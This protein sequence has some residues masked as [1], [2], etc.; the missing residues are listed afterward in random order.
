MK[1]YCKNLQRNLNLCIN[2]LV[3]LS[4]SE[5]FFYGN[6]WLVYFECCWVIYHL[7]ITMEY[8]NTEKW[9]QSHCFIHIKI[10]SNKIIKDTEPCFILW[11]F[12][13]NQFKNSDDREK[14]LLIKE[15]K[16]VKAFYLRM[17]EIIIFIFLFYSVLGFGKNFNLKEYI[18]KNNKTNSNTLMINKQNENQLPRFFTFSGGLMKIF[19]SFFLCQ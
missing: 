4:W 17:P 12:K 9:N 8:L 3:S 13:K 6:T 10:I 19:F 11:V 16:L 7:T 1:K 14:R 18:C 15:R 5:I 2:N